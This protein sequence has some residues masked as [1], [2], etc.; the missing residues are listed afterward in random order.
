MQT[1]RAHGRGVLW[2]H[3]QVDFP[4]GSN[5]IVKMKSSQIDTLCGLRPETERLPGLP[6][7]RTVSSQFV[8]KL[9]DALLALPPRPL[10]GNAQ[11][12][13]PGV[14]RVTCSL[15]SVTLQKA[16]TKHVPGTCRARPLR[17]LIGAGTRGRTGHIREENS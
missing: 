16:L 9:I 7:G 17:G 8:H 13:V 14:Q 10:G 15:C 3:G 2:S 11:T 6:L 12:V 4:G 5:E 1:V